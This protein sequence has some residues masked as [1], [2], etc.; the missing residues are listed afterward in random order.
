MRT[1]RSL[2]GK[3][4][5]WGPALSIMLIAGLLVLFGA[6]CG[7]DPVSVENETLVTGGLV[8]D[9]DTDPNENFNAMSLGTREV[10]IADED[11]IGDV[12]PSSALI[13][14]VIGGSFEYDNGSFVFTVPSGAV[15]ESVVITAESRKVLRDGRLAYVHEFG[16]DGLVFDVPAE[17][18]FNPDLLGGD[19]K[20][21][22][23]YYINP[24]KRTWQLESVQSATVDSKTGERAVTLPVRHFSK[25]GISGW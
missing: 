23:L 25:Y 12:D 13:S 17:I 19:V 15:R 7:D 9:A 10:S 3:L 20:Y 22:A 24:D 1:S 4:N 18:S 16:P 11:V 21:V 6:G 14:P 5:L 8:T 2:L